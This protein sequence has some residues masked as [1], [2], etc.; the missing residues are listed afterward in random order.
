MRAHAA[1]SVCVK[2]TT[3]KDLLKNQHF[4][5]KGVV[6][7]KCFHEEWYLVRSIL[8]DN[9][10]IKKVLVLVR[11]LSGAWGGAKRSPRVR[12]ASAVATVLL[13]MS[14]PYETSECVA[15]SLN[16]KLQECAAIP[17]TAILH[18]TCWTKPARAL[19]GGEQTWKIFL[20]VCSVSVCQQAMKQQSSKPVG[21]STWMVWSE[22]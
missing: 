7:K 13:N 17:T 9:P 1:W 5:N 21:A 12:D 14:I 18:G 11:R 2:H 3:K 4:L 19:Q 6:R 10:L 20:W 16:Q 22:H 15:Q 8:A